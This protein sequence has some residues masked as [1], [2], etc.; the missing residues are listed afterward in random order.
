MMSHTQSFFNYWFIF[1]P[2]DLVLF[3]SSLQSAYEATC[4]MQSWHPDIPLPGRCSG[5]ICKHPRLFPRARWSTFPHMQP[6]MLFLYLP[7]TIHYTLPCFWIAW[8][9]HSQNIAT[10]WV[11]L[12][13]NCVR[14]FTL[15]LLASALFMFYKLFMLLIHWHPQFDEVIIIVSTTQQSSTSCVQE[16]SKGDGFYNLLRYTVWDNAVFLHHR[17]PS[18]YSQNGDFQQNVSSHFACLFY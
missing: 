14:A 2:T 15:V 7:P 11:T 13:L 3:W 5:R 12:L 17:E 6:T 4:Q 9:T 16:P 10:I 8:L 18:S 1:R